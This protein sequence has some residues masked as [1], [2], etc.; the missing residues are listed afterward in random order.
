MKMQCSRAQENG[1]PSCKVTCNGKRAYFKGK[2]P[3]VG[4]LSVKC[5]A[6][7]GAPKYAPEFF[8]ASCKGFWSGSIFGS[9]VRAPVLQPPLSLRLLACGTAFMLASSSRW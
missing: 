2:L 7:K 8:A 3:C 4:E 9:R 6:G 5:K 1:G